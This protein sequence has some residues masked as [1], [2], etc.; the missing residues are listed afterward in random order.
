MPYFP[1][2]LH[3]DLKIEIGSIASTNNRLDTENTVVFSVSSFYIEPALRV[4]PSEKFQVPGFLKNQKIKRV[5]FA[6]D[7]VTHYTDTLLPQAEEVLFEY[8]VGS[9]K[10]MSVLPVFPNNL[11]TEIE[12]L[13]KNSVPPFEMIKHCTRLKLLRLRLAGQFT[14]FESLKKLSSMVK[15]EIHLFIL[16][17]Q[18][19]DDFLIKITQLNLENCEMVIEDCV[20]PSLETS[21][22]FVK[23]IK[24]NKL[25]VDE[26]YKWAMKLKKVNSVVL[27]G[28]PPAK[29]KFNL[30]NLKELICE[31]AK[32]KKIDFSFRKMTKLQ[33]FELKGCIGRHSFETLSPNLSHL[34]ITGTGGKGKG[35]FRLDLSNFKMPRGIK[36]LEF[37]DFSI[38]LLPNLKQFPRLHTLKLTN[39]VTSSG[40]YSVGDEKIRRWWSGLSESLKSLV[41]EF[42]DGKM[43]STINV[44]LIQIQLVQDFLGLDIKFILPHPKTM[45]LATST[46]VKPKTSN[47]WSTD[48]LSL[49][50]MEFTQF[51]AY[52]KLTGVTK[53]TTLTTD[54]YAAGV[55]CRYS[56][57]SN[58][59][60]ENNGG[61]LYDCYDM[62]KSGDNGWYC[63]AGNA[64]TVKLG[65]NT[66]KKVSGPTS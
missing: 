48:D 39:V 7:M 45:I 13:V 16:K 3:G 11:V 55:F 35:V 14:D 42:T 24:I 49:V 50:P 62:G 15:L 6:D 44:T 33:R 27:T 56:D 34:S 5:V 53:R 31:P 12:C 22:P 59:R 20:L 60:V 47:T 58:I 37:T 23:N 29:Y 64:P 41:I 63:F 21:L 30:R 46:R 61:V 19:F 9:P 32:D 1:Y 18:W 52:I 36:V 26:R 65:K 28:L 8:R 40:Y 25:N 43:A 2:A 4:T 57:K 10:L 66:V 51:G 17:S 54:N 38:D